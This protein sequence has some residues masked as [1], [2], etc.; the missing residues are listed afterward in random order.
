MSGQ[1]NTAPAVEQRF[2]YKPAQFQV[3]NPGRKPGSRN[4]LGELFIEAMHADFKKHGDSVIKEVRE[5]KPDQYL[6]VIASI[7]PR[8]FE[9]DG[10]ALGQFTDEQLGQLVAVL[11]GWLETHR[12]EGDTEAMG[13]E[14][15]L[16]LQA[17]SEAK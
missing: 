7:L 5:T 16:E 2:P 6:K 4:K 13:R 11:D 12:S 3:G 10:T 1:P 8:Q 15:A 14:P 17:L 9:L